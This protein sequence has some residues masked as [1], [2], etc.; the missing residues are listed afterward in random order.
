MGYGKRLISGA[1]RSLFTGAFG[2]TLVPLLVC[3][4]SDGESRFVACLGM[5][6][7]TAMTLTS[8]SSTPV[9]AYVAG[10]IG[11]CFWPFRRQ[12][13][14]FRWGLALTLIGLDLVMKAPV[15]ALIG[16]VDLTGSSSVITVTNS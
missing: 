5:A 14:I 6:G 3:L 7:A 16:R 11:L 15:W 9:L 13:R 10:I 4:W 2:A 12:M 8:N 1:I